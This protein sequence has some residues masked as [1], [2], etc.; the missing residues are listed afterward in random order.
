MEQWV[1][2]AIHTAWVQT[3]T[4]QAIHAATTREQ[5]EFISAA[6]PL[7]PKLL[8]TEEGKIALQT[9]IEDL[10]AVANSL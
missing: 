3:P 1:K 7:M 5:Q 8:A 4:C 6:L 10:R 9:F 2:D